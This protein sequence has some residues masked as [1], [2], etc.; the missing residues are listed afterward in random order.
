MALFQGANQSPRVTTPALNSVKRTGDP[1][2]GVPVAT[3]N[4]SG[5]IVQ[6]YFGM[7]GGKLTL[8][9]VDAFELT[10]SNTGQLY[11]GVYMYVQFSTTMTSTVARG[12]IALWVQS[13]LTSAAPANY[14][15][16][17]DGTPAGANFVAGV[18]INAS[19]KGNY[20][21]IQIGGIASVKYPAALQ[22]A[23]PAI[24]DAIFVSSN[25]SSPQ[26]V[27]DRE[28]ATVSTVLLKQ[29]IGVALTAPAVSAVGQ[30][31]LDNTRWIY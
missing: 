10:D 19:A 11:G 28:G 31:V 25:M 22:A 21:F 9:Q 23:T 17:C 18:T 6:A 8:G 3:A 14:V 29:F 30:V 24:G 27:D 15:V 13:V 5:S 1:A 12:N 4:V 2:P 20:D 16:T 7:V 26:L